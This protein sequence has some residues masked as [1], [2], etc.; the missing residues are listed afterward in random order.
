MSDYTPRDNSG[1]LFSNDKGGNDKRPDCRGNCM[2]GGTLYEVAAWKRR[3]QDGRAWLSLAFSVPR[4][5]QAEAK[6]APNFPPPA[7]ATDDKDG[8]PF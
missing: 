8:I 2:I 7:G 1:A 6:P 4:E 3:T 5:K